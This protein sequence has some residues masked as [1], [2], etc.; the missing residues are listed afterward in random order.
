MKN[1]LLA[2]NST[3]K[4][5]ESLPTSKGYEEE[6]YIYEKFYR[7]GFKSLTAIQKKSIPTIARRINTLIV[8]PTGSGKTEAAVIPILSMLARDCQAN[9]AKTE[10]KGIKAIY[11]TP[12]RAL[13]NDVFRRIIKY[14]E[15]ENLTVQI[16]HGDTS[17]KEKRRIMTSPP[18]LLITTPES[19][20]II[21]VNEKLINHLTDLKWVIIDEVHELLATERGS[22]L[23]ISLERL[24][25]A[26]N[27]TITRV[28]MSASIGNVRE[29]AK[30]I[31]G[32]D[33]KSAILVDK[34]VRSYDIDVKFLKGS[35]NDVASFVINYV[36][37][38][39]SPTDG[40]SVLLFTNT[41]D[42]A[43]YI[44]TILKNNESM[45][46]DVHH[47]SLSREIREETEVK[48]REG[49]AGIVVCTSSLELG[50]DL[51]SVNLVIHYGSPRQ[52]TKLLQRIG[53]SRHRQD[54]SAK[55]LIV[56]NIPDDEA[57]ALAII[58]VMKI[59]GVEE[60]PVHYGA[61]DVLAHHIV[62]LCL[63]TKDNVKVELAFSIVRK[64]YPFVDITIEDFYGCM[65]LLQ[66]N[67]IIR[68][69][70]ID[71]SYTRMRKAYKYYFENISTIPNVL[72]FEVFDCINNRRIGTL[73]QQFVGDYGEQGNVFVLKG[74]QW[75]VVSIEE[76][77]MIINVEPLKVGTLNVPYW[78][79][80]VI[81]IDPL[82]AQYVGK[83]RKESLNNKILNGETVYN[84]HKE[85]KIIPTADSIVIER[86]TQM[87]A[88]VIHSVFGTKINNSLA[89]LLS[90]LLSSKLGYSVETKSDPYRIFLTSTARISERDIRNVLTDIYEIE[91]VIIASL[92]G[93]PNTNWKVWSVAKRFGVISREA[94]YDKKIA[95]MIYDRYF[96][97]VLTKEAIREITHDKFDFHGIQ[98]IVR[99]V[100]NGKIAIYW[101]EVD[102]FS[103]LAKPITDHA[104]RFSSSPLSIES[105]II[106]LM[107]ERLEKTRQRIICMRCG[108]WERI[109]ETR[110]IPENIACPRCRSRL[111]GTTFWGNDMLS[112]KITMRLQGV[113]LTSEEN[114]QF[115]KV[116]KT[117]S[118]I[119]TFG[120]KAFKVLAGHGIGPDTAARILRDYVNDFELYKNIYQAERSYVMTRGFWAD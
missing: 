61:L 58:R 9:G 31:A 16:R 76:K 92:A 105:G 91:D 65:E 63:Q 90:T 19:L 79:G 33:K 49:S 64:A 60:Q 12:L 82:T 98:D 75:R 1:R 13:N 116:W 26:S 73:D 108:K 15:S 20:A 46:V 77:R 117:A 3:T 81:P 111:I 34:S 104:T 89:A 21:L 66:T 100:R 115:D 94:I 86:S 51:G 30:F 80:E 67:K 23:S 24:Q 71:Q 84:T 7:E 50:L 114:K 112:K 25:F 14:A 69:N 45:H 59:G 54:L 38:H 44:G 96:D 102:G 11:I 22:H 4:I 101:H 43:E 107:K 37:T 55:G 68:Y 93:T 42:E 70:T 119:N 118:L 53:R 36:R 8:A 74:S 29:G 103:D 62:G 10:N 41:R 109:M 83:I 72:K 106:E 39:V 32:F 85:L 17:A 2:Q 6:T 5:K 57:E 88:V 27:Y 95:R 35:I 97:T 48:L 110:E 120:T 78:V 40:G 52:V 28:G 99:K 87:N 56:T 113:K 47:G 18:D